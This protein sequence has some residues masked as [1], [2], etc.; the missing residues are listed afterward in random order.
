MLETIDLVTAGLSGVYALQNRLGN[1]RGKI[2]NKFPKISKAYEKI[3]PTIEH[4]CY[5][6][7]ITA[8]G[9][10]IQESETLKELILN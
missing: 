8:L 9:N 10:T 3:S 7:A 2:K 5:G 6:Y 4:F 1:F